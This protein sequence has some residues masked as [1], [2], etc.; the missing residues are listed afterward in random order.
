V[1]DN[2]VANAIGYTPR[3]GRVTVTLAAED[4]HLVLTVTD[5][6]AGIGAADLECVFERFHRGENA[7]SLGI[8]GTGLG[9]TI[10]RAIVDAHG[11]EVG[12]TSAP[13]RGTTVRVA[14]PR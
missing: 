14:L 5:D 8:P 1:V 2:L 4:D 12:L 3:R 11:G 13:G 7:R 10:V 9:L 6:G